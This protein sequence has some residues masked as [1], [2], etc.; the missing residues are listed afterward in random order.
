MP[1]SKKSKDKAKKPQE[2]PINEVSAEDEAALAS[3]DAARPAEPMN[4]RLDEPIEMH[5]DKPVEP[6]P[7]SPP[8]PTLPKIQL[9][10][11]QK[12][13]GPKPDQ[14]AGFIHYAKANKLGPMTV[15]EWKAA[16]Q[17]FKTKPTK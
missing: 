10:V 11:F 7:E 17:A 1:K 9:R 15:P 5:K 13:A 6:T 14:L 2:E 12:I 16:L 8:E 4:E 3:E